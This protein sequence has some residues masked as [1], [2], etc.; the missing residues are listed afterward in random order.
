MGFSRKVAVGRAVKLDIVVCRHSRLLL[1]MWWKMRRAGCVQGWQC[2]GL[3]RVAGSRRQRQASGAQQAQGE[4]AARR[5]RGRGS[6]RV[7]G[8][9]CAGCSASE[10][11]VAW[12]V[13]SH[14]PLRCFSAFNFNFW[15]THV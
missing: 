11:D 13:S 15:P 1:G 9:W 5:G 4:L 2:A 14:S 3:G 7:A 12:V 8:W 6:L 10:S